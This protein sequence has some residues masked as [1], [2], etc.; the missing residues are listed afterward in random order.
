MQCVAM[1][2]AVFIVRTTRDHTQAVHGRVSV[3]SFDHTY[4]AE[5][6]AYA[7]MVQDMYCQ[8]MYFL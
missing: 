2:P 6:L 4:K 3:V 1:G 7:V 8:V 5:Q